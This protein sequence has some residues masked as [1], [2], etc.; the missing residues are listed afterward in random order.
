[1]SL[2]PEESWNITMAEPDRGTRSAWPMGGHIKPS[3]LLTTP[4]YLCAGE[5]KIA[6]VLI[7]P[8][9]TSPL[10]LTKPGHGSSIA[11]PDRPLSI[12]PPL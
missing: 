3:G 4:G 2:Q 11:L 7:I 8:Y 9:T 10:S 5:E 1:M 12:S 6:R